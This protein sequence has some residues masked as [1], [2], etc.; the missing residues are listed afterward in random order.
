MAITGSAALGIVLQ[1]DLAA[2]LP[3]LTFGCENAQLGP[4]FYI[5]PFG[6]LGIPSTGGE[7][8]E[9]CE[10]KQRT[11]DTWLMV[12]RLLSVMLKTGLKPAETTL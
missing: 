12:S 3:C 6:T 5:Q 11:N 8:V 9:K 2:G 10:S 1:V 7:D 4:F